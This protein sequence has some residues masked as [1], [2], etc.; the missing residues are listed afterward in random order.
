LDCP[1]TGQRTRALER[2]GPAGGEPPSG[3]V[4]PPPGGYG[5]A[6]PGAGAGRRSARGSRCDRHRVGPSDGRWH[7]TPAAHQPAKWTS[8]AESRQWQ[9]HAPEPRPRTAALADTTH[10]DRSDRDVAGARRTPNR[11]YGPRDSRAGTEDTSCRSLPAAGAAEDG[12]RDPRLTARDSHGKDHGQRGPGLGQGVPA[13]TRR[14]V[15][16]AL[17]AGP[18]Y[19][20]GF[21]SGFESFPLCYTAGRH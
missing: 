16:R 9:F 1:P 10:A 8:R 21:V 12:N 11:I 17:T 15:V 7:R 4:R 14:S 3:G 2:W 13:A 6:R 18:D 5:G 20:L 19:G